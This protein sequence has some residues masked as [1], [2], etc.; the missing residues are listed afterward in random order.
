[1][2]A[3]TE[4]YRLCGE[5]CF[6]PI[7]S[8]IRMLAVGVLLGGVLAISTTPAP[9]LTSDSFAYQPL[10]PF[11][12]EQEADQWLANGKAGG[13]SPWHSDAAAT[14]LFFTQNFLGFH[15]I[16]QTTEVTEH[17]SEAWV[18]VGHTL[19]D[20]PRR[21]AATI[22]L[23]RFGAH[24]DSPWEVAGTRDD[25]LT[26]GTPPYGSTVGPVIEA[27]G[28]ITGVDES[29][30]LQIRQ[31]GRPEVLGDQC[32]I[33]AGGNARPW[34]GRV[35]TTTTPRPGALTLVVWTGGHVADV[36]TF[37]VTGLHVN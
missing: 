2:A 8:G 20:G 13:H 34:S 5:R 24:P 3:S 29:L 1:M 18:G 33:P 11:A 4:P 10:W 26:I 15:D 23:A 19:P 22:H 6:L 21:T 31:S 36:E 28:T 17:D 14:A 9:T 27:G 12:S 37:A 7:I 16:D 25:A 30:H 35:N 32:C